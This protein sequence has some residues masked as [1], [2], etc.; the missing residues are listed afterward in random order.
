MVND[1]PCS[2]RKS[3]CRQG[4][5]VIVIICAFPQK[6]DFYVF[7]AGV[8]KSLLPLLVHLFIWSSRRN[9]NSPDNT[10]AEKNAPHGK[11]LTLLST[12]ERLYTR[13][14]SYCNMCIPKK[15]DFYVF[16][17]G[18]KKSLLP[19]LVHL[20]IW[21]SRFRIKTW[22]RFGF[23]VPLPVLDVEIRRCGGI[24]NRTMG[25]SGMKPY[26]GGR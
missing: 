3:V 10:T 4:I 11:W 21:S 20:F 5:I 14:Y 18:V 13:Y 7:I 8:K 24:Q 6:N 16:M 17:A 9:W 2:Q 25:T 26:A 15:I 22:T 12:K 1:W 23:L 19:L